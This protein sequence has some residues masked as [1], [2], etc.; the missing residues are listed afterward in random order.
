MREIHINFF[1]YLIRGVVLAP[2]DLL[3]PDFKILSKG[4]LYLHTLSHKCTPPSH[5]KW[6]PETYLSYAHLPYCC[7]VNIYFFS[8]LFKIARDAKMYTHIS[9]G[10]VN[11]ISVIWISSP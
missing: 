7:K 9:R 3:T 2:F 8:S 5:K 4:Q 6:G 11:D 1:C 10:P